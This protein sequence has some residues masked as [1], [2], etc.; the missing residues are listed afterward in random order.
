MDSAGHQVIARA[1]RRGL[2]EDRGFD[3]QEAQG[4]EVAA[5]CLHQAMAQD[6][7]ALKLGSPEIQH[8]VPEPQ[9]LR[10]QLFLFL[11]RYRYCRGLRWSDDFE[12]GDMNLDLSRGDARVT[13][14]LWPELHRP[15]D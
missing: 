2:R 9:L 10:R 7:V 5:G 8:P 3:L 4:V 11:P 13:R 1:F 12:V 6:Q 14:R 15:G